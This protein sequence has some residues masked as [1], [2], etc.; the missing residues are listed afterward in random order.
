MDEP[1]LCKVTKLEAYGC[2]PKHITFCWTIY[3][4]LNPPKETLQICHSSSSTANIRALKTH[5]F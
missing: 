4:C 3:K 1:C 2:H 5:S